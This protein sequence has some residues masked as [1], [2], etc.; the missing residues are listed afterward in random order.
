MGL[1]APVHIKNTKESIHIN[2]MESWV[3]KICVN[4][5]HFQIIQW[6]C[7]GYTLII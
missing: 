6:A 5:H 7:D 3:H 4:I 2:Y 1:Y